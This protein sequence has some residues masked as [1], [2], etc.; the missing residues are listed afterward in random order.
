VHLILLAALAIA[1]PGSSSA[2]PAPLPPLRPAEAPA[3]SPAPAPAPEAPRPAEVKPEPAAP[4]PTPD[5]CFAR[6][7][8]AGFE[9]EEAEHPEASNGQCRIEAPVRLKAVPVPSKP[10]SAVRFPAQPV[11]ACRFAETF[12]RWVGDLVAP[13]VAGVKGTTL[14]AVRTG[15]GFACR[16]RNR[17][18]AGK[19]SAHAQGIA[20]DIS[21][22]DLGDGSTLR[23]ELE[24]GATPDPALAA[25]RRGACGWFTTILGP[26]SDA[27]HADHLHV[28]VL[29]H[30][31]S[32]RY[33]ICE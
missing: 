14:A 23:I 22:F 13:V 9:A 31:S 11:L 27:A 17:A 15:P 8:E 16:N 1:S 30:G 12:G 25:V 5:P 2:Q 10:G 29:V 6:L 7:R 3:P 20:V 28:D 26:G 4:A 21:A 33:R 19:L 24:P 32:D 18:A